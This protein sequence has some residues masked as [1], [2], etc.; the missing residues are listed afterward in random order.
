MSR[1]A[2]PALSKDSIATTPATCWP[3][4]CAAKIAVAAP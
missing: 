4:W 1:M 3:S 2:R